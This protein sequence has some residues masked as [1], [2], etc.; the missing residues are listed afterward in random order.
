MVYIDFSVMIPSLGYPYTWILLS[1]IG[2]FHKIEVAI[3][4]Q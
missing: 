2:G 4:S 3:V 1:I